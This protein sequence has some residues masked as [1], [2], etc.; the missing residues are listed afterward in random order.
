MSGRKIQIRISKSGIAKKVNLFSTQT[1]HTAEGRHAVQLPLGTQLQILRQLVKWN[2]EY[3]A[4]KQAGNRLARPPTT[5][6]ITKNFR[7]DHSM[8]LALLNIMEQR[9][10]V[11]KR[12]ALSAGVSGN[13][14]A[15]ALHSTVVPT[16][17]AIAALKNAPT[18]PA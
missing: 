18:D 15:G 16:E 8:T 9:G 7:I 3:L 5:A 4:G 13:G 17:G 14:F 6:M 1:A 10:L 12:R 11:I 2:D